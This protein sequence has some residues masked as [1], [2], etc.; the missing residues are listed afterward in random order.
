MEFTK[1]LEGNSQHIFESL[2]AENRIISNFKNTLESQADFAQRSTEYLRN[3][4]KHAGYEQTCIDLEK[5]L[6]NGVVGTNHSQN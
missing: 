5:L 4:L 1:C 6:V 3:W 2:S